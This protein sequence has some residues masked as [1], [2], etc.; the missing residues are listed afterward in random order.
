MHKAK[1]LYFFN[2]KCVNIEHTIFQLF[3][4]IGP[5]FRNYIWLNNNGNNILLLFLFLCPVVWSIEF[6][7]YAHYHS[8]FYLQQHFCCMLILRAPC[9]AP[10][11]NKRVHNF[12][13]IFAYTILCAWSSYMRV[14][15][16]PTLLYLY[17]LYPVR[18]K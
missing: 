12:G 11:L 16:M 2:R 5:F 10:L 3:F 6:R 8:C 14:Y 1:H 18:V 9:L 4:D 17:A 13:I 7:F 15:S